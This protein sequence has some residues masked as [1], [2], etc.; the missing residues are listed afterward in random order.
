MQF[1]NLHEGSV[2]CLEG[3]HSGRL[4]FSGGA[5]GLLMAH[6]LRMKVRCA[7]LLQAATACRRMCE[8]AARGGG[9]GVQPPWLPSPLWDG[10]RAVCFPKAAAVAPG[11][12]CSAAAT[13][14]HVTVSQKQHF[15]VFLPLFA[16]VQEASRVLWHH[17]SG[18]NGLAL[19]DP[20]L[21]SAASGVCVC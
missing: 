8:H 17:N 1:Q 16:C 3:T 5:D 6:D 9:R 15:L 10:H 11:L 13:P 14:T 21:V 12:C 18:V 7:G 19:E 20:W 2:S 4:L